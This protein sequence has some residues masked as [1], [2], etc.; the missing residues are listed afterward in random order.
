M[1][2][3]LHRGSD[4]DT[5][6]P[7]G[8]GRPYAA[9]AMDLLLGIDTGGTFTD[10]VAVRTVTAAG[11]RAGGT[12]VAAAKAPTTHG[13]L[14]TGIEA[15]V[16]AVLARPGV[17][18]DAIGLVAL[19]T[20]LATN[21]LVEGH[22]QP[23]CLVTAGFGPAEV[24]RI[25]HDPSR[26]DLLA[27]VAG[28]HDATGTELA[29]VDPV[30]VAAVAAATAGRVSAYAVA[31]QF[32]V[33]NP[34]HER[35]IA[36]A[37]T[38]A[39]GLPVTCSHEL[40]P[41]LN[42]PRRALT[43][44]LNAR[45]IGVMA[46]LDAAVR[47]AMDRVGVTAPLLVV[48]GD[49]SLATAGFVAHRPIETILSGPAASVVGARHLAGAVDGLVVDIGGTTTDIAPVRAGQ[50]SV[51]A[52]G[53][54]VAGHRTM[55][56]ALAVTTH[57]LGGDS[58]VAVLAPGGGGAVTVP[59]LGDAGG[60][61]SSAS[62][63]LG[64]ERA[65]PL[66]RLA[67]DHP[68]VLHHLRRQLDEYP[69]LGQGRLLV[70]VRLPVATPADGPDAPTPVAA[71]PGQPASAPTASPGGSGDQAGPA[72]PSEGIDQRERAVLAA[73]ADG[74]VPELAVATTRLAAGA[75][76]RLRQRGLV[77]VATVTPTDAACLLGHLGSGGDPG[78]GVDPEAARLGAELLARQ[79]DPTGAPVAPSAQVLAK[80]IGHQLV[81]ASAVA[82]LDAALAAD[83]HAAGLA[84]LPE[85]AANPT[86]RAAL[87]GHRGLA[88]LSVSLTGPIVAVGASA[89]TWY[90][91]VAAALGTEVVL[92]PHGPVA[93][94]VGAAVAPVRVRRQV[95]IT[96]P[97][98]GT[99]Q[100]HAAD[101]PR[102]HSRDDARRWAEERLTAEAAEAAIDAGGADPTV[103]LGWSE[104]TA[105]VNG[106]ELLV[107][108]TVTAVATARPRL[109]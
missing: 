67:V 26:G 9:V 90:P 35:A 69:A 51:A 41:R 59:T 81:A 78:D 39:S 44:L 109:G 38:A 55:V 64:P 71:G 31:A 27:T 108:A 40:S 74:P 70:A 97:R 22:G 95:T 56:E 89:P 63:T 53:A 4:S 75:V 11:S 76:R 25:G 91:A 29:P 84:A 30:E 103:D 87:A 48:R 60:G 13:D 47:E 12:V 77:R 83:A 61:R 3:T 102:F 52:D 6:G 43:T 8:T 80:Q 73:L 37:L 96:Q 101:Q 65:V 92:P 62:F 18:A 88:A 36:E 105:R 32:S 19:S 16:R 34:A 2:P 33:R 7:A 46:R 104:R 10:A 93:N 28:G 24:A 54:V 50:P 23:A 107:E 57:G 85:A 5:S 79:Q 106:R 100:V 99:F 94:A 68:A 14:A 82:V 49:G 1:D 15:A 86:L 17:S 42:G 21:A 45:L 58:E 72:T 66:C 98:T 20:T